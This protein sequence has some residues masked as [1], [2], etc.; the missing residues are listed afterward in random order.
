M[1]ITIIIGMNANGW[2]SKVP[3]QD[4]MGPKLISPAR[5]QGTCHSAPTELRIEFARAEGCTEEL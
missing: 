3:G 5:L 4:A 1:S 2:L